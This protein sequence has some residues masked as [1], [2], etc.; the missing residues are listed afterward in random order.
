MKPEKITAWALDEASAEER[1]QLEA[2]LLENP[3]DKQKADETKAFCDFLLSELRDDSLALTDKQR[4]R[5]VEH[6]SQ[7]PAAGVTP[8]PQPERGAPALRPPRKGETRWNMVAIVRL[9]VAACAV[10]GGFWTWQSY[11]TRPVGAPPAV[12]EKPGIKVQL[13]QKPETRKKAAEETRLLAAAPATPVIVPVQPEARPLSRPAAA[14]ET[15]AAASSLALN[16]NQR[17]MTPADV[18]RLKRVQDENAYALNFGGKPWTG[19]SPQAA[20]AMPPQ[21]L[22]VS[23]AGIL[24]QSGAGV[25]SQKTEP[26]PAVASLVSTSSGMLK[27]GDSSLAQGGAGMVTFNGSSSVA[28]AS[29]LSFSSPRSLSMTPAAA[30][31]LRQ[32]HERPAASLSLKAGDSFSQWHWTR[33]ASD[34]TEMDGFI[35]LDRP[36]IAS[37]GFFLEAQRAGVPRVSP[38]KT[39]VALSLIY[40]TRWLGVTGWPQMIPANPSVLAASMEPDMAGTLTDYRTSLAFGDVGIHNAGSAAVVLKAAQAST[41][42]ILIKSGAPLTISAFLPQYFGPLVLN[43]SRT[44]SLGNAHFH[45]IGI[46]IPV[47]GWFQMQPDLNSNSPG[48]ISFA[49]TASAPFNATLERGGHLAEDMSVSRAGGMQAV[50]F[51][52]TELP[53]HGH[54]LSRI[55]GFMAANRFV[56]DDQRAAGL[57]TW[58]GSGAVLMNG[59]ASAAP[60]QDLPLDMGGYVTA[61]SRLAATTAAAVVLPS[62]N[63]FASANAYGDILAAG[64]NTIGLDVAAANSGRAFGTGA[65]VL[66]GGTVVKNGGNLNPAGGGA[67]DLMR[68][69]T[70]TTKSGSKA[71]MTVVREYSYPEVADTVSNTASATGTPTAVL[72]APVALELS[73][74]V[75]EFNGYVNYGSTISGSGMTV[76]GGGVITTNGSASPQPPAASAKAGTGTLALAAANTYTGGTVVNGGTLNMTS[77]GGV[78]AGASA[79]SSTAPGKK[80]NSGATTFSGVMVTAAGTSS[81]AA[82]VTFNSTAADAVPPPLI[83]AS[84]PAAKVHAGLQMAAAATDIGS[85]DTAIAQYQEVLRT[86]PYNQA[87]RRGMEDADKKRQAYFKAAYDNQRSK[88]LAQVTESWEDKVP[89][90]A[91]R[92]DGIVGKDVKTDDFYLVRKAAPVEEISKTP[93]QPSAGESYTRIIENEMKEVAREPLSTLSIDVDTASYANVRRFLNQNMLPP[94]DA[95]RI[96]ELVNYFPTSEEG[97]AHEAKQP[98]GVRIE[99]APCPWQPVHRLARIAIKGREM[100][101]NRKA[102]NLVF[103]VDVSGSMSEPTKLPLVQQSLRMLT[104]QLGEGDHVTMVVYAGSSGVV[105]PPTSGEKKA[106]I[107]AAIDR[108]SAGGST[109]GS[110][111]IQLAYEQAVAGFI[112]GGVNRVILCTDGDFNVG[113]SSPEEL[114]KLIKHKAKTGVFLSV[115]GFGSGN[116]QD[117]TMET[118]ADKGNGNYAYIDSL[119]EAR[120]VLVE[121]MSGTLDT[122]AKDVKIQIEFN[123]AAVR[124]YRLIG[125]ENRV[126]AKEDFNDDT[127]DAGEI[128]A[129]HSVVALYEVVPASLPAGAETRPAVDSL[130]YQ[131]PA[132]PPV[133]LADP[134]KSGEVMTVK[135]RYKEPDSDLSKLIE[136]PVKDEGKTLTA[137]TEEFKF[138]AAVA[139]FGLLLRDSGY[140]GSLSWETVRRLALDGKGTDKLGYRGEF[141]QLVDKARGLKE[142]H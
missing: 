21:D 20:Q 103:L 115:L 97:P 89:T 114:E 87:A 15:A 47:Y 16:K 91:A 81:A 30:A 138:S 107:L 9:A 49:T 108:L 131:A 46:G 38:Q 43:A 95:V 32:T 22:A 106:E 7:P 104:E 29:T 24:V 1:Q 116:L 66:N 129:G 142:T 113:V 44:S 121:Q 13:G 125:Y 90:L 83:I 17:T 136:A 67:A 51:N 54:V 41:G 137:S 62:R 84:D 139:G 68:G 31:L 40:G 45:G 130:K 140:K 134:A 57:S 118:L 100:D 52:E 10:L 73:P 127:K 8:A 132:V 78:H 58:L 34:V 101:K 4:Q 72:G 98:F 23:G 82:P 3:Q 99:M 65:L 50:V 109:H 6:A 133:Q 71:T 35:D 59:W 86:D 19:I 80:L 141:L 105:L 102:S 123:P 128:G 93:S 110:A 18:E 64:A 37:N 74:Q 26:S 42:S 111:G 70:V 56:L 112:K 55:R 88:M 76:T 5:L 25:T 39:G 79:A 12:A 36:G 135:L 27:G 126:M 14:P 33:Q 53:G 120:K 119:S 48:L 69:A 11:S 28:A 60:H 117:R 61:G 92:G 75:V 63:E 77:V 85:Y 94:P 124:S 96:E 122:I 2:A